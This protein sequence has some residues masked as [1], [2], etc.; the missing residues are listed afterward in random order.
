MDVFSFWQCYRNACGFFL[1]YEL[2][3]N[4]VFYLVCAMNIHTYLYL[5]MWD[6]MLPSTCFLGNLNI[7]N[8]HRAAWS[9]MRP[10]ECALGVQQ[11]RICWWKLKYKKC[12][13]RKQYFIV[14]FV[15]SKRFVDQRFNEAIFKIIDFESSTFKRQFFMNS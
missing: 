1:Y 3:N 7:R 4:D 10:K 12:K 8:V 14:F 9:A 6:L 15:N 13:D 2:L 5:C 11:K